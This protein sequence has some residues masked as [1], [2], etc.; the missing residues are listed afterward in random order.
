LLQ[1]ELLA[2]ERPFGTNEILEAVSN[3]D[4]NKALGLDGFNFTF[5]N[6]SWDI[7]QPGVVNL[8]QEFFF[9][10]SLPKGL[11]SLLPCNH[12]SKNC[13]PTKDQLL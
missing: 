10:G 7:L 9:N 11:Y 3:C 1:E 13:L 2:L 6:K 8:M 5:L 4:G 12:G